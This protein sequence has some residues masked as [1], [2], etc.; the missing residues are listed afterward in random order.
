MSLNKKNQQIS[1]FG[2]ISFGKFI[3]LF[4]QGKGNLQTFW[5]NGCRENKLSRQH[6]ITKRDQA[7][8][9]SQHNNSPSFT[10]II[11]ESPKTSRQCKLHVTPTTSDLI[12]RTPPLNPPLSKEQRAKSY[13]KPKKMLPLC[14]K[15]NGNRN[16][17]IEMTDY[18]NTLHDTQNL[19]RTHPY[20]PPG[21]DYTRNSDVAVVTQQKQQQ[22]EQG[23]PI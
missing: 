12:Q 15:L 7:T 18:S 9:Y 23:R 17:Q 22:Q 21:V 6:T 19:L 20:S 14:K 13:L 3:F 8:L 11:R 10:R 4:F 5:L 1:K 2:G 16:A